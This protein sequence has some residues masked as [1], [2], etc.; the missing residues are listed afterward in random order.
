MTMRLDQSLCYRRCIFILFKSLDTLLVRFNLM[1]ATLM[2]M[3]M[4]PGM[5]LLK[6]EIADM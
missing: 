1:K 4:D 5:S 3:P 6:E 2:T